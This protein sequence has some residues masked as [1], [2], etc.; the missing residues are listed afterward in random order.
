MNDWL[1]NPWFSPPA[2]QYIARFTGNPPSEE[3][4]DRMRRLELYEQRASEGRSVFTGDQVEFPVERVRRTRARSAFPTP[5]PPR[6]GPAMDPRL[7]WHGEPDPYAHPDAW[8]SWESERLSALRQ[9]EPGLVPDD[10]DLEE[11]RR[12]RVEYFLDQEL[13]RTPIGGSHLYDPSYDT[14]PP[15]WECQGT[16]MV[17]D[18]DGEWVPCP[19]CQQQAQL[20]PYHPGGG[21]YL[22]GRYHP[23]GGRFRESSG[24][25][26]YH[27]GGRRMYDAWFPGGG[28]YGRNPDWHPGGGIRLAGRYH[29]G[30][31]RF[32][33]HGRPVQP[34]HH[35]GGR[36]MYETWFPGGGHYESNP[37]IV[38][39]EFADYQRNA[40]IVP[41]SFAD[42]PQHNPSATGWSGGGPRKSGSFTITSMDQE[43]PCEECGENLYVGD[44]AYFDQ[45]T[46]QVFCCQGCARAHKVGRNPYE[47]EA[48]T[49]YGESRHDVLCQCGWGQ[50]SVPESQIPTNCPVCGGPIGGEPGYE[51]NPCRPGSGGELHCWS[52]N[53]HW[54]CESCGRPTEPGH[55]TCYGCHQHVGPLDNPGKYFSMKP[56]VGNRILEAPWAGGVL[57]RTLEA[58]K[59]H[60]SRMKGHIQSAAKRLYGI[61]LSD[62]VVESMIGVSRAQL[63]EAGRHRLAKIK[64]QA[65]STFYAQTRGMRALPATK[66]KKGER[67]IPA[68]GKGK[69]KAK[70]TKVGKAAKKKGKVA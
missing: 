63:A 33:H 25:G 46:D 56:S 53:P 20:N 2:L 13:D 4:L 58:S 3:E 39:Y 61:K 6:Q 40:P 60:K 18:A 8:R 43:G 57:P 36:R 42:Y 32:H 49:P 34:F 54:E 16:R 50:L 35:G 21:V 11:K 9:V 62:E 44:V 29:P 30:G 65:D 14:N 7:G 70:V 10:V 38:D 67:A 69:K 68:K 52:H 24:A 41:Y 23:G 47:H 26:Y 5:R 27:G 1:P 55:R 51:E 28:Y 31:G 59:Q 66:I 17:L 19:S 15:C 22:A 45:T 64:A 48:S 12:S 37:V